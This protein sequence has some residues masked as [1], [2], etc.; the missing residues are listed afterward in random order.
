[1]AEIGL[2]SKFFLDPVVPKAV[3][4]PDEERLMLPFEYGLHPLPYNPD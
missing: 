4:H 3:K 1:M 2:I